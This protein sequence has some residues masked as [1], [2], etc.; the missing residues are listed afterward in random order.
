[1][2]CHRNPNTTLA[3]DGDCNRVTQTS[4]I[5]GNG[6]RVVTTKG[7]DADLRTQIVVQ[8]AA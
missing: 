8:F 1:M 3:Y 4:S 5:N 6:Q 7:R 2:H